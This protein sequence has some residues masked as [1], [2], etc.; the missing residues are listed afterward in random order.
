MN[1]RP[2]WVKIIPSQITQR[3]RSV[4]E[5]LMLVMSKNLGST[6]SIIYKKKKPIISGVLTYYYISTI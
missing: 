3:R 2:G 5:I 1:L 6:F 4:V